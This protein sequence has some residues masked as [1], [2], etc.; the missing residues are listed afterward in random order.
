MFVVRVCW[1]HRLEHGRVE[2]H[3]LW[4]MN[5]VSLHLAVPERNYIIL[6]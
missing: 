6:I 1:S 2:V 4:P 3:P 5:C